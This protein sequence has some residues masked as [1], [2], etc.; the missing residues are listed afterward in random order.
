LVA[1]RVA[2]VR[3]E[4]VAEIKRRTADH[5]R[6]LFGLEATWGVS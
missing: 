4:P 6:R 5:A 3:E 1:E 2:A